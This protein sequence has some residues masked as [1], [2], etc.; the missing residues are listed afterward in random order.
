MDSTL[1][2]DDVLADGFVIGAVLLCW[3]VV[4]LIV[5]LPALALGSTFLTTVLRWLAILLMVTGVGNALVYAIARGIVL[6][7][8]ARF[9]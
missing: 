1:S 2:F 7:E 3:W 8:E 4:A 5:T 6:S 9:Q